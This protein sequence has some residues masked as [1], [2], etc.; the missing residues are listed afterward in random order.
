[1]LLNRHARGLWTGKMASG[2]SFTYNMLNL[3]ATRDPEQLVEQ[4]PRGKLGNPIKCGKKVAKWQL[5]RCKFEGSL[6]LRPTVSY[7]ASQMKDSLV[8]VE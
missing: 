7:C 8:R 3:S 4:P 1:M 5:S 2:S 6:I